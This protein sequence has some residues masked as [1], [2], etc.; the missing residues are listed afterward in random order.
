MDNLFDDLAEITVDLERFLPVN[1]GDEIGTLPDV[2]L[3]LFAP[4]HPFVV[5]IYGFHS[6]TSSIAR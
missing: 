2:N 1:A 5:S 3:V 6:R 4:L